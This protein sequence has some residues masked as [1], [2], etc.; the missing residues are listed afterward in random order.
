MDKFIVVLFAIAAA[1]FISFLTAWPVMLL[2]NGCLIDAV[3][4]IKEI[5]WMQAWGI[6]ILTGLLFKETSVSLT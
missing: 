3:P 5:T 4:V 2:W 1:L 6:S